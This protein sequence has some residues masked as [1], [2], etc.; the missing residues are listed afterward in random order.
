MIKRLKSITVIELFRL[1]LEIK[2]RL[3]SGS[4]WSSGYFINTV[5][6][7]GDD[8][9]ISKFVRDLGIEKDHK[10]LHKSNQLKLF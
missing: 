1:H 6:K 2:K 9:T 7:F 3:W 10:M 5:S 4:F 8:S